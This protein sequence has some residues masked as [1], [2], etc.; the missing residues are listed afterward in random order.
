MRRGAPSAR[1]ASRFA[2]E[3][4][5]LLGLMLLNISLKISHA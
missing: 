2:A 1:F 4:P 3:L 5:R